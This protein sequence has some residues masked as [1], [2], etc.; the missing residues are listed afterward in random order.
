MNKVR[1]WSVLLIISFLHLGNTS[2][3]DLSKKGLVAYYSF[4][5]CDGRDDSTNNTA[6][7]LV[8]K[9]NC[10]CGVDDDGLLLDGVNAYLEFHGIVNRYF[11]T[12]DFTLSFYIKPEGYSVFRQ[13]LFSKREDCS[14]YNMLDLFFDRGK[15]EIETKVHETPRK[16]YPGLSPDTEDSGWMHFV[17]TR[18]GF[19][20]FTYINGQL[21]REGY[22]CSGVDISNEAVLS[23]SNSPCIEGGTIRRFK[24]IIDEVRVYDHALSKEEVKRLYDLFPIENAQMDCVS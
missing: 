11:T 20:A 22:R 1:V 2:V 18:E 6:A 5:E 21:Q 9:V 16:F 14:E 17:L 3:S 24:G 7:T 15:H 19:R 12:S 8:G 10:W 4:N 13:S 23:F